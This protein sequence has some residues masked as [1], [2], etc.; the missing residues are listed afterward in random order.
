MNR[1]IFWNISLRQNFIATTCR[2][3]SNCF[4]FVRHI[5]MLRQPNLS[6]KFN[7]SHG[8]IVAATYRCNERMWFVYVCTHKA[9]CCINV[10]QGFVASPVPFLIQNTSLPKSSR[11]N[12]QLFPILSFN[13]SIRFCNNF[14]STLG[15]FGKSLTDFFKTMRDKSTSQQ[16]VLYWS[17][18]PIEN[19]R[20]LSVV[21]VLFHH[22][23]FALWWKK[24]LLFNLGSKLHILSGC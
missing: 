19:F 2:T 24:N 13:F 10:L 4:H 17:T 6:L 11:K 22:Q 23:L 16:R 12:Y 9:N 15:K 5:I 20:P 21:S 7:C 14:D 8:E 1:G 18:P 3:K